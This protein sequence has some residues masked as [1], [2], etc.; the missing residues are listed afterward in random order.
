M[1]SS[2]IF[3]TNTDALTLEQL[4]ELLTQKHDD[5][6]VVKLMRKYCL[7]STSNDIQKKGMEFLYINGFY[8]DLAI[9]IQKNKESA[10]ASNRN[11]AEVYDSMMDRKQKKCAPY[12]VIQRVQKIKSTEPEL[13]CLIEFAK[14]TSYYDMNEY[15]KLGN[16]LEIQQQLFES[17]ED[18]LLISYFNIRLHQTLFFYYLSRNELIIA[19]KYAYR[20]LNE[21]GNIRTKIGLHINLGLSY[22][23]ETYFQGM[24]HLSEALNLAKKENLLNAIKAIEQNNIPFLSAH[25]REVDNISSTDKSEQAHI[26]IAKGNYTEAIKILN[27]IPLDSPY[28]LYYMGKA[29]QD[30]NLLLKSYNYFIEKRSDYFFSRLPLNEIKRLPV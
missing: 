26:E 4:M 7:K 29:K 9:L 22:T 16:F 15:N 27:E 28:K 10:S 25:F 18:R 2:T 12:Q 17:I 23:F 30:K 3:L 11:W 8:E 1:H 24:Y 13:Q 14:V 6:T 19:R 21:T 20:A 5:Q